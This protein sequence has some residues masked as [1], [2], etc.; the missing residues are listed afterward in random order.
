MA[1]E[2]T[3]N[4]SE[5]V[6]LFADREPF[7]QAVEA[8]LASG[9]ER[10]D[11]SVL[12]SHESLEAAGRPGKPWREALLALVGEMKYE[13]PLVASGAILLAGG[14]LAASIAA[15]IGAAVGGIAIKDVLEEMTAQPHTE[16]FARSLAAGAVILWVRAADGVRRERARSI[17]EAKG[18]ANVHVAHPSA[19]H[20][21]PS[22]R[23]A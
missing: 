14:P 8:L 23:T 15:V 6:G 9:F 10:S 12:A 21:A 22:E 20:P 2:A 7:D 5:V 17:L 4:P 11:L 18:A 3:Q 19:A 1:T 13:P 16:D